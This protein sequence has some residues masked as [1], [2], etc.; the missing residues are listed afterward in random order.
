MLS[1]RSIVKVLN[2]SFKA[3]GSSRYFYNKLKKYLSKQNRL[4][5]EKAKT[6]INIAFKPCAKN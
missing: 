2:S 5:K 1:V 3:I 6:L 4:Q